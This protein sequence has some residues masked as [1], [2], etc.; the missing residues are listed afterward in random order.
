MDVYP[1]PG[2]WTK[3]KYVT[4]FFESITGKSGVQMAGVHRE[5]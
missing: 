3:N 2:R 4:S 1:A 5:R